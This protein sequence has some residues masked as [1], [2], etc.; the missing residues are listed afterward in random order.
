M[1]N[2]GSLS[3]TF[4][5]GHESG[6]LMTCPSHRIL[7][8]FATVRML[9]SPY[10]SSKLV[11]DLSPLRSM[12]EHTAKDGPED[13]SLKHSQSVCILRSNGPGL[14]S[15]EDHRANQCAIYLT[16]RGGSRSS[17]S[18]QTVKPVV[19]TIPLHNASPEFAADVDVG[20]N[21]RPE[22]AKLLYYLEIVAVNYYTA[23]QMV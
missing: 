14:V 15:V 9:G 8:A 13:A 11:V 1:P 17:G 5:V 20:S 22:I 16:F 3:N 10:L 7:P 19:C 4:L 23:S 18:Q 12:L 21:D 6:I 2:W